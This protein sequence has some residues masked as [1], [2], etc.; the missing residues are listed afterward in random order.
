MPDFAMCAGTAAVMCQ[1]CYRAT[2][3]PNLMRQSFFGAPPMKDDECIYYWPDDRE[4]ER[5]TP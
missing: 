5:R 1:T 3:T 2:A 4:L